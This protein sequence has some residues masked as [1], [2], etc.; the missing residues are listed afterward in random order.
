MVFKG[1][2]S[3]YHIGACYIFLFKTYEILWINT[4][5]SCICISYMGGYTWIKYYGSIFFS[6]GAYLGINGKNMI[7]EFSRFRNLSYITA[8]I[9]LIITIWFDGRNTELGSLFHPLY[10]I[11]G[12]CAVF[13]LA[14][15]LLEK[16]KVKV[17]PFLSQST[18]F[19]Y[20]VHTLLVLW[21]CSFIVENVIGASSVLSL[22]IS[23]FTI[24]VLTVGAC[25]L[26]FA[27]M[28]KLTPRLLGILTGNRF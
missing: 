28:K 22:I 8:S 25:L 11:S 27:L 24:P 17:N 5:C 7:V 4:S 21:L 14:A 16:N 23:Y 3:S 6:I 26:L 2:D 13:N 15:Q 10:I 19:I 9:F 20:A 12:V 1:F 18:F